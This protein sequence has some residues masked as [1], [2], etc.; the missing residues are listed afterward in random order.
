MTADRIFTPPTHNESAA[1]TELARELLALAAGVQHVAKSSYDGQSYRYSYRDGVEAVRDALVGQGQATLA[2]H[3]ELARIATAL[4]MIAKTP[5]ALDQ[6][7]ERVIELGNDVC[8]V[9]T[10]IEEGGA[11]TV[12]AIRD[13]AETVTDALGNVAEV[14]DRVRWWQWRRR[15]FNRRQRAAAVLSE[16]CAAEEVPTKV[17]EFLVEIRQDCPA[18]APASHEVLGRVRFYAEPH[19]ACS[20]A[21]TMLPGLCAQLSAIAEPDRQIHGL[22]YRCD[23]D[24]DGSDDGYIGAVFLPGAT[25]IQAP[26]GGF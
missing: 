5:A 14:I 26:P 9:H 18:W 23:P 6:I 1:L 2:V 22:V 8:E 7:A 4:E 3:A 11:A 25:D 24:S 19:A 13:H 21:D 16:P 17:Y 20:T 10:A 15:W 12:S